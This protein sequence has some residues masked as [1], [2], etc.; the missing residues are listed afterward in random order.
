MEN[1]D[2]FYY[3]LETR[4]TKFTCAFRFPP[5][6]VLGALGVDV[7]LKLAPESFRK[8]FRNLVAFQ[9]DFS[10]FLEVVWKPTWLP[11]PPRIEKKSVLEAF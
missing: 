11:N 10:R 7:S 9:I 5:Y 8:F 2:D 6:Q 4:D 3:F 1:L